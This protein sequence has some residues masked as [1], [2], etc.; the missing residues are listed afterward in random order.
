MLGRLQVGL[1]LREA[2]AEE[3]IQPWLSSVILAP[4]CVYFLATRGTY[5][6]LD[7]GALMIHEAGHFA[8]RFFGFTAHL[9][10]GT[11]MQLILPSILAAHFLIHHYR[12]GAQ[13][14]LFWLGHNCLNISVYAA[15]ARAR[16]LPLL[17]GDHV[18]HDWHTLLSRADLLAY[19]TA[20]GHAFVGLALVCFA[21]V[22]ILP[23]WLF[24]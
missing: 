1:W 17:G 8:F 22:L 18:L 6:W 16:R 11:L 24:D 3:R 4:V 9:L 13:L 23:Y 7:H 19:D 10:G 15:D 21:A 2:W 14:M 5:T 12:L 20:I